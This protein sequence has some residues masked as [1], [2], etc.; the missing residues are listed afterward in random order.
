MRSEF[1]THPEYNKN[2]T[3][4]HADLALVQV[5]ALDLADFFLILEFIV[6][7]NTG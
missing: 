1:F 2:V 4:Y 5:L 7:K 3:A 6:N